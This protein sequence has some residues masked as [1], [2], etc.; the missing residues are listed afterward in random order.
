LILLGGDILEEL[1]IG[2]GTEQFF[3]VVKNIADVY[4]V[5]GNHDMSLSRR[6]KNLKEIIA[7]HGV[8]VLDDSYAEININGNDIVIGGV[9]DPGINR[10]NDSAD[11]AENLENKWEENIS[12]VFEDLKDD[13][14]YK[15]LLSHRPEKTDIYSNLPFDLIL[16]GHAHGGQVRIPFILNGLYAPNQG[17]FPKYAGGEYEYDGKI[18]IVSRGVSFNL[19]LPRI[20]NPPEIVVITLV[21]E[22]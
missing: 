7:S 17:F 8:T 22:S 19:T 1:E 6:I 21:G 10:R 13:D 16:S 5:T 14:R 2:K 11:Y 4:Y 9:D 3:E 18:H 20:F 15:I 12:A